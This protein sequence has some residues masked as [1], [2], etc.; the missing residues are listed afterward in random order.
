MSFYKYLGFLDIFFQ[1]KE[2]VVKIAIARAGFWFFGV[3]VLLL[4]IAE[5]EDLTP[6]QFF[7]GCTFLALLVGACIFSLTCYQEL[8]DE[9]KR[10]NNKSESRTSQTRDKSQ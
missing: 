3:L 10:K 6:L 4:C 5:P 9:K 7:V 2:Y 1:P 8:V